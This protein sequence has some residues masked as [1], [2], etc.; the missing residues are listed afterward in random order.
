MSKFMYYII[1]EDGVTTGTNN[2]ELVSKLQETTLILDTDKGAILFED[3][4]EDVKET[5]WTLEMLEDSDEES[6]EE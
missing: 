2:K 4:E 6:N 3:V 5:D 1:P